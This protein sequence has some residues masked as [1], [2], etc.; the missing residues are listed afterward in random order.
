[1]SHTR[2]H[3]L[4]MAHNDDHF[5]MLSPRNLPKSKKVK[6]RKTTTTNEESDSGAGKTRKMLS[7]END[8]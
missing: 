5:W 6:K 3:F 1:M 4:S 7:L 8:N 2:N